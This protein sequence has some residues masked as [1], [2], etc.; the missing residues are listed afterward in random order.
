MT[1]TILKKRIAE[2]SANN[3]DTGKI[4]VTSA[5]PG[6]KPEE[7]VDGVTTEIVRSAIASAANQM[8]RALCRTAYSPII[9]EVLDFAG[10]LYD[11]DFRLLGQAP[12]LPHFMGTLSFCIEEAVNSAGGPEVLN[13]GDILIYNWPYGT[14]SHAND[15]ALI[16][17]I[18]YDDKL[19]AYS[20]IKGHWLDVGATYPYCTNTT[21]VY[22]EGTFFRGIK[23]FN[24]GELDQ[25]I[26]RILLDNSRIPKALHGDM[27]AQA[28]GLR[29]GDKA[30][31]EL[32]DRFGLKTFEA[33]V[34]QIFDHGEA[35]VRR[36]YEKIPDGRYVGRGVMD[37]D[38]INDDK[39]EFDVYFE[40]DG[41]SVR[42]DYSGLPDALEGPFNSPL[43]ETVAS[44]RVALA[45]LAGG[46]EATTEGHFRALEVVTRVGSMLHPEPPAPCFMY[47]WP[48]LQ[49][50]DTIFRAIG[51]V[52]PSLVPADPGTDVPGAVWWGYREKTG[53]AW[54][55]G[56]PFPVG[57]GGHASG[58][59][60]T[61]MCFGQSAARLAPL[62]VW[63]AKSPRL[64]EKAEFRPDSGG[65]GKFRGGPGVEYVID[66]QED[67]YITTIS[68]RTKTPPPG[69]AGGF[70]ADPV[71]IHVI[72][73]NGETKPCNKESGYFLE[74]GTRICFFSGGGGGWGPA[75]ER[76]PEDVRGDIKEGFITEEHARKYYPHAFNS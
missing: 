67:C 14:G 22:Q 36:F 48:A 50:A 21:D 18:F 4:V 71:S 25:N 72:D 30:L 37:N 32:V 15:V 65:A 8:K 34:E 13:P 66:V 61:A 35:M 64:I 76:S 56:H 11:K 39:I 2:T 63:E 26:Y 73:T 40:V 12:S 31:R 3:C 1:D 5:L 47:V 62:E 75:S 58:D 59:G 69:L 51:S 16:M 27:H 42:V 17:P 23:L 45:M 9:Y 38:G 57:L 49:A 46:G 7:A 70:D 43:P 19:F 10:G 54:G 44:T 68:E 53:E 74:K 33:A 60:G 41:S 55:D 6:R 28:I 20:A 29:A 24:K 52:S